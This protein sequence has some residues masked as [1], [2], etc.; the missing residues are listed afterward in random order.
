MARKSEIDIQ[1][2]I[3]P[4]GLPYDAF[5]IHELHHFTHSQWFELILKGELFLNFVS[6]FKQFLRTQKERFVLIAS[7]LLYP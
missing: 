3:L 5:P 1:I 2:I 4:I 7:G 6:F